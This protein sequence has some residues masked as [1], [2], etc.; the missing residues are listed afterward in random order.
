[1]RLW[2][3]YWE[4]IEFDMFPHL[5]LCVQDNIVASKNPSV[6]HWDCLLIHFS[7]Y[8]DVFN[9]T[10]FVWIQNLFFDEERELDRIIL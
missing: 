1:M 7:N 10:E 6:E 4:K 8:F 5:H 3:T 9:F 2:N